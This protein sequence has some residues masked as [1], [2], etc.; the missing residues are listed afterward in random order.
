MAKKKLAGDAAPVI[1]PRTG[2]KP[3]L[4]ATYE[5]DGKHQPS[6]PKLA[7]PKFDGFRAVIG[8]A[9]AEKGTAY[10]VVYSK[11]VKP[12]RNKF[13]QS[14]F[15]ELYSLDGELVVGKPTGKGVFNRT[16]SGVTR[17]EGEPDVKFYVFDT[18]A[19]SRLKFSER[20]AIVEE[21]VRALNSENVVFVK[22][23]IVRNMKEL[24][25]YEAKQLKLG[26]EGVMLRDP[27]GEYKFGRAT[28]L[29]DTL[30]KVKR[31]RD[32]EARVVRFEEEETNTNVAKKDELGR[33]KRS[34][35]KAGKAKAGTLGTIVAT[36]LKTGEEMRIGAGVLKAPERKRLWE[37]RAMHEGQLL[38]KYRVFD[39]GAKDLPR[40]PTCQGLVS[41]DDLS[42]EG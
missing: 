36:D 15:R 20:L 23:T 19:N 33:S 12:L 30:W 38:V 14:L 17:A 37:E 2:F 41:P 25:A 29:E 34:S 40:Y 11:N 28:E 32:G 39:Y 16:S 31:F 9:A 21:M 5:A 22:H 7:S 42:L 3:M 26:Y 24:L 18:A 35:A 8:R 4:A 13:T 6:F 1:A 10:G 27:D